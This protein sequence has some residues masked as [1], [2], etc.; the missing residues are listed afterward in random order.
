MPAFEVR[1]ALS[2]CLVT[3][4]DSA[5]SMLLQREK[6]I[7]R[8]TTTADDQAEQGGPRT[9]VTTQSMQALRQSEQAFWQTFWH[10]C[11]HV[12]ASF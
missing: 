6:E 7:D 1:G 4:A 5:A 2:V 12:L 11:W 3:R 10:H 9:P 8:N